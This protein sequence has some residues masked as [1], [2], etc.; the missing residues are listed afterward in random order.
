MKA[1][2]LGWPLLAALTGLSFPFWIGNGCAWADQTTALL[3]ADPP[4]LS[5]PELSWS[6]GWQRSS[7]QPELTGAKARPLPPLPNSH[8]RRISAAQQLQRPGLP[9]TELPQE[10]PVVLPQQTSLPNQPPLLPW[11]TGATL[12]GLLGMVASLVELLRRRVITA[13]QLEISQQRYEDIALAGKNVFW[14]MDAN[15]CFTYTSGD[16]SIFAG[17]LPA[18]LLGQP[19]AKVVQAHPRFDFDLKGFEQ[20]VAERQPL[21]NFTFRLRQS[22]KAIRIF[23]LTG[24]PILSEA[25]EFSGYRGITREITEELHLAETL[26]YQ[27]TYD[28]LTGLINRQEFDLRLKQA[29]QRVHRYNTQTILCYLDLDQFKIVNDTAGH[30]VGD[31][32]LAEL[33]EILK[34]SVRHADDLGRLGG[35]EFGLLLEGCSIDQAKTLCDNLVRQVQAFRFRWQG[36]QFQVGVSIG[37]VPILADGSDAATLLSQ[38][39]MACYRAKD[40]GRGR[41]YIAA[42]GDQVL[43]HRRTQM[44]HLANVPLALEENR[45]YLMQQAIRPV[46]EPGPGQPAA[47]PHFEVLLRLRDDRGKSVSPGLFIPE[48]ER[49]G[50]IGMIDRWVLQTV[51]RHGAQFCNEPNAVVSVN[52]SGVS[53]ADERFLMDAIHWIESSQLNPRCL[54]LEITET[55]AISHLDQAKQFIYAMKD[56]GVRFA[57]DDFGSGVSSF[58]YLRQLPVDY[59]KIDGSLVRNMH[60]ERSDRAIV[61]LVNDIAHM[62]GMKTIAEFVEQEQILTCLQELGVDYAQGYGIAKPELL[63]FTLLNSVNF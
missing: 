8:R 4:Q 42:N 44:L 28:G 62:M 18:Q 5:P 57:L 50:F 46:Q 3:P 63:G 58:G 61:A 34:Q 6:T 9:Q 20:V 21:Y 37:L 29:V 25:G 32:L 60:V 15:L 10:G 47:P 55:A 51:L 53:L 13:N 41:V 1:V 7:Q 22:E 31:R 17:L 54:C 2:S 59:L 12:A 19:L 43:A 36:H 56:L 23:Q 38:A 24:K 52:L 48:A 35:D 33:A 45:F 11:L 30:L 27:A 16:T 39:D 40:L 14:E 49:Y 26:A